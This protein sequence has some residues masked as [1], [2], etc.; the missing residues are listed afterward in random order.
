MGFNRGKER[1]PLAVAEYPPSMSRTL[2]TTREAELTV[3]SGAAVSTLDTNSD[4]E[5]GNPYIHH[6]RGRVAPSRSDGVVHI[7][8]ALCTLISPPDSDMCVTLRRTVEAPMA[9]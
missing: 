9:A 6:L 3:E 5:A 8:S 7:R 1:I 4:T 2:R